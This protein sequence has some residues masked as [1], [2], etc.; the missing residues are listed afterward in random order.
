MPALTDGLCSYSQSEKHVTALAVT[1][2]HR[3]LGLNN[4]AGGWIIPY[5]RRYRGARLRFAGRR[6][7]PLALTPSPN[8]DFSNEVPNSTSG[9]Q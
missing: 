2:S 7:I 4:G 9:L 3:D 5:G 1:A 8:G 6:T